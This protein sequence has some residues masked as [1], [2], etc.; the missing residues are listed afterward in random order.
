ME[1]RQ[2]QNSGTEAV[3]QAFFRSERDQPHPERTRQILRAHP[4]VR[5]LFGR[6]PGTAVILLLLVSL[7][8]GL[9]WGCGRL[10]LHYWWLGLIAAWC[11]GAFANHTLYVI[12]HEAAHKLIFQSARLNHWASIIADLPNVFPGAA[13]FRV[14]HLKHHT[15]QGDY[16]FDADLANRWEARLIGNSTVGKALWQLFFPFFQL[17]RPPRLR[18]IKMWK[19]WDCAHPF[20]QAP[21][22]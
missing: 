10:G 13:G 22:T 19:R 15:H 21:T 4:E 5:D 7:Q 16:E 11:L 1:P 6:N 14:Y 9:A 20:G 17:S 18:A 2:H 8:T 3:P 12:I